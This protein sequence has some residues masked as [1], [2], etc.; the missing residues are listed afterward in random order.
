MRCIEMSFFD[1][2]KSMILWI[3]INMRCIE[4]DLAFNGYP[5]VSWLTLTWDVLKCQ[6]PHATINSF[7]ININMRCIEMLFIVC[8]L[9]SQTTD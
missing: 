6:R 5:P 4:I 9:C 3:N 1:A 7:K 8:V 2:N